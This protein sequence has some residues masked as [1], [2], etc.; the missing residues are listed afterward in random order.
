MGDADRLEQIGID[1]QRGEGDLLLAG[2][3]GELALQGTELL[4][5]GVRDVERIED[6]RL[7]NLVGTRLHHQDRVLGA[8][9]DQVEV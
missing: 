1:G 7:G 4:D 3:L 6:L 2:P 8:G 5:L 9:H